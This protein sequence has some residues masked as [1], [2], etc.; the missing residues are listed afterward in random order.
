MSYEAQSEIENAV[1][2]ARQRG[3]S[4]KDFM[5]EARELWVGSLADEARNVKAVYVREG[6]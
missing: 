4:F 1:R 5:E 3:Y 2:A 6:S